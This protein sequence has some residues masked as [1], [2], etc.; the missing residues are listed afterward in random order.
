MKF[1]KSKIKAEHGIECY[2][3][4][5]GE[6]AV[7]PNTNAMVPASV[8]V[9][10]LK[11]EAARYAQEPPDLKRPRL[12]HGVLVMK[13]DGSLSLED[14]ET[15]M[16]EYGLRQ[17]TVR[18]THTISLHQQDS[19][20]SSLAMLHSL[21]ETHLAGTHF[22]L[23]KVSETELRVESVIVQV[24]P[25]DGRGV[26]DVRVSWTYNDDYLGSSLLKAFQ[27]V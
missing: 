19:L 20:E 11:A 2:M 27:S 24:E 18:F 5:N 12:L 8:S 25:G 14:P 21:M 16:A 6:T 10:L 26:T 17:H 22:K 7:I 3:P 13:G 9:S 1:L 4:A 15:V 23:S